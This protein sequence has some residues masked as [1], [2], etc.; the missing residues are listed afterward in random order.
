MLQPEAIVYGS[1]SDKVLLNLF[2][3][4]E[5]IRH[6]SNFETYTHH[7]SLDDSQRIQNSYNPGH[8]NVATQDP[9]LY[10]AIFD[11]SL[12]F[13]AALDCGLIALTEIPALG[14]N[15]FNVFKTNMT[16]T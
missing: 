15:T 10:T 1:T 8:S 5:Y 9:Y 13:E 4:C 6:G 11:P 16:T 3:S 14:S 2:L 7:A 12:P